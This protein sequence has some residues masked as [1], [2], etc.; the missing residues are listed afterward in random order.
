MAC[1][2][3]APLFRS[4]EEQPNPTPATVTGTLP[5]WLEGSLI[6]VGPG[7]FDLG[8]FTV[9]HWFDGFAVLD[10]IEISKGKAT[11]MKKFL[12][13]DAYKKAQVAKKPVFTEF[14]TK[15]YSDVTKNILSRVISSVIPEL[16][17]N[18]AI[19]VFTCNGQVFV[20]SESAILRKINPHTLET[21]DKID[22]SKVGATLISSH[23]HSDRNGDT[24][25]MATEIFT[26]AHYSV[27][28]VPANSSKNPFKKVESICTFPHS[29]KGPSN[30]HSFGASE[31]YLVFIEQPLT[32]NMGRVMT[33]T[34]KGRC[35]YDC[36]EWNPHLLNTFHIIDKRT[37][38]V[39]PTK[40][41][42]SKPFF[43]CHHINCYE[44]NNQLVVDLVEYESP[45]LFDQMFLNV[46]RQDKF[47]I[48]DGGSPQ[49]FVLPIIEPNEEP[50]EGKNLVTLKTTATAEW[51]G[52]IIEVTSEGLGS[53]GYELPCINPLYLTRKY[54]YFYGS[55][56]IDAGQM[57]N[58]I[59]KVDA[60]TG[61]L[62]KWKESGAA[63]PQ[64]PHMVPRPGGQAEDDGVL[65]VPLT[66][67]DTSGSDS[68]V[69]LDAATLKEIA[70]IT[71][72]CHLPNLMHSLFLPSN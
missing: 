20:S 18:C 21:L 31:N 19:N 38:K 8:D 9:N 45:K 47:D 37:G 30:Y 55:G 40:Y 1:C 26:S 39:L 65:L 51:K 25:T 61:S 67:T 32:F 28:K 15:A 59:V 71:P 44:E 6:R 50:E 62:L 41:V 72:G 17:D 46:V 7:L 66:Y 43:H 56:M 22:L 49:R 27:L 5:A 68:L 34:M 48:T 70:R 42:S 23:F 36:A 10:K 2:S 58:T 3:I 60:H 35:L 57:R 54:R 11:Y 53:C 13:S 33:L 69:V 24:Y 29:H 4:T 64:G 52:E 63:F 16:T 12:Q 14:G